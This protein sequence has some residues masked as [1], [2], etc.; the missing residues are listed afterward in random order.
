MTS[1]FPVVCLLNSTT[2]THTTNAYLSTKYSNS[3]KLR[4]AVFFSFP[5]YSV[6]SQTSRA[7]AM[8]NCIVTSILQNSLIEYLQWPESIIVDGIV[9]LSLFW[10]GCS[11]WCY[12]KSSLFYIVLAH[13]FLHTDAY[14]YIITLPE[15]Q[16]MLE[17]HWRLLWCVWN[18]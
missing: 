4:P 6:D 3:I 8:Q 11:I 12:F 7:M 5:L 15:V 10:C 17:L 1:L 13:Y 18:Q 9:I 14:H 16:I 2:E